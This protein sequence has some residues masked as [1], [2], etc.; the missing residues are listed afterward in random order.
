MGTMANKSDNSGNGAGRM[1]GFVFWSLVIVAVLIVGAWTL[2]NRDDGKPRAEPTWPLTIGDDT[3]AVELAMTDEKRTPGLS[4]R[5]LASLPA[6]RGMLFAYP[7]ARLPREMGFWMKNCWIDL[8]I[9][10]IRP[11]GRIVTIHTMKAEPLDRPD[12][13]LKHYRPSE[14]VQFALELRAGEFARRGINVG[15][16]VKFSPELAEKVKQAEP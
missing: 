6:D 11:D 16:E 8:D 9:A 12:S 15:D 5:D 1:V 2:H 3:F 14:P 4:R 13:E 7:D 10:F